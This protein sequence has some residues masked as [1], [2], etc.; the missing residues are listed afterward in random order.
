MGGQPGQPEPE[1]GQPEQP[2]PEP[3][4]PEQP[5][6]EQPEPWNHYHDTG[7]WNVRRR[8][9]RGGELCSSDGSG[10]WGRLDRFRWIVYVNIVSCFVFVF[11]FMPNIFRKYYNW[12]GTGFPATQM[13][14]I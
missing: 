12:I 2:E 1:P 6:P 14:D 4:Q 13:V 7:R 3:G 8:R 5:E 11:F 9:I 10:V